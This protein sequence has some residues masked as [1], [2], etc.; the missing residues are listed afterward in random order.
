MKPQPVGL[1]HRKVAGGGFEMGPHLLGD[2]LLAPGQIRQRQALDHQLSEES[3]PV[4]ADESAP[5]DG[6]RLAGRLKVDRRTR[7][8][9][10]FAGG[11]EDSGRH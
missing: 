7:G 9:A 6:L 5:Q 3:A 4:G 10:H 8:G 1:H 11:C 2:L